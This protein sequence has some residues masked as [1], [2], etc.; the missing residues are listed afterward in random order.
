MDGPDASLGGFDW[1]GA[2]KRFLDAVSAF[3]VAQD[4]AQPV[5]N[6]WQRAIDFWWQGVRSAVPDRDRAVFENLVRQSRAFYSVSG[7]FS[8]ILAAMSS[9]QGGQDWEALLNQQME[10]W[11]AQVVAAEDPV[12]HGLLAIWQLPADTW[13][14]TQ[15]LF[16]IAPGGAVPGYAQEFHERIHVGARL[17]EEYQHALQDYR[18]SLATTTVVALNRLQ[19]RILARGTA[20]QGLNSLREIF[21]LWIECSESAWAEQV[22]TDEYAR[23]YGRLVNALMAFKCHVQGLVDETLAAANMPTREGMDSLQR[24][25]RDMKRGLQAAAAQGTANAES[26][27]EIRR[28][29]ESLRQALSGEGQ[30]KPG[31]D[32]EAT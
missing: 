26:L 1:A 17:W 10:A 27:S 18:T 32:G 23:R 15:A 5:P 21:D 29:L 19:E 16:S 12:L 31:R 13:Q 24:S 8:R 3:G 9:P 14:R 22:F 4:A 6:P 25:Q 11:R 7:Q 28:E 20:G 2:Q 30:S